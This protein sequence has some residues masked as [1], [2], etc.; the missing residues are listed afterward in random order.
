MK[1]PTQEQIKKFW[2]WCGFRQ[3][4]WAKIGW[5]YEQ[6]KK[7]MNWTHDLL[8]YGS[9]DFLPRI[10]LD[11]LFKYAVPQRSAFQIRTILMDWVE[12][13]LLLDKF[14]DKECAL[15]LFW[16]LDKVRNDKM[17]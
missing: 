2:E 10:D 14:D 12:E 13:I 7:V 4:Q 9:L 1:E 6:T 16:V 17:P 11:N 8:E 5:H 15:A 3:L